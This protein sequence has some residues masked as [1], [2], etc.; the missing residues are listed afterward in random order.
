M[1]FED[2]FWNHIMVA[3]LCIFIFTF[4]TA[5]IVG[6]WYLIYRMIRPKR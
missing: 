3:M 2:L 6:L 4:V 5:I 1:D